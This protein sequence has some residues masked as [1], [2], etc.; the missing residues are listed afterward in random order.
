MHIKSGQRFYFCACSSNYVALVIGT[1]SCPLRISFSTDLSFQA[2]SLST[3]QCSD[4]NA[5]TIARDGVL[6]RATRE[7]FSALLEDCISSS[8]NVVMKSL[9]P[10]TLLTDQV[11]LI[12]GISLVGS[13]PVEE[14]FQV[15][16]EAE[17]PATVGR[18]EAEHF[19]V[20]IGSDVQVP[21]KASEVHSRDFIADGVD[22]TDACE[23]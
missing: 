15:R 23:P 17:L 21:V 10:T 6:S 11:L 22:A 14:H 19:H 5:S 9:V 20:T 18:H 7:R 1:M 16:V 12:D 2:I 13:K 3:W 8:V 4:V